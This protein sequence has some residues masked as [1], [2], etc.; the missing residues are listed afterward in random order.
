MKDY[1]KNTITD[2]IFWIFVAIVFIFFG[3]LS[4][5][6]FA[7]DT[8]A[9]LSFTMKDFINQFASS[10][11]FL[12]VFVG[13]ILKILNLNGKVIYTLSYLMAIICMIISLYKLYTIIKDDVKSSI[14]KVLIPT[15]IVLNAFSLE[16][17]LF[18]EKG[19]MLFGVMMS[20][21]AVGEIKKWLE[22]KNKK[23]LIFTLVYMLFA[24]FSYQGIVGIFVAISVIYIVKYSKNIKEFIINNIVVAIQYAIP[25]IIDYVLIKILYAS[26]RV[27]GQ[28]ILSE[29]IRKIC[30]STKS[31]ILGTYNMLPKYLFAIL[32][33]AIFCVIVY[34]IIIQKSSI[35]NK[36]IEILK[37]IY[38]I[39]AVIFASIAPQIMQNTDSIWFVA[40]ST[41]SYA[42]LFGVLM[43]YLFT[44]F[45]NIKKLNMNFLITISLILLVVQFNRFNVI[46]ISRYKTNEMDYEITRKI[47]TKITEYEEQTGNTIKNIALYEDKSMSYAYN[48]IFST[49]DT[50]IK[51]YAKDWC[52]TYILKYYFNINLNN[53]EQNL[54]IKEN[55]ENKDWNEFNDDQLIF[56]GDTLHLCK[57]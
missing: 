20:I 49:G 10:G 18:V 45:E 54:E 41:Y 9:T 40:R 2:K 31:M 32:V 7:V 11:R 42:S 1:I 26:S 38:I 28:I 27:N 50:N 39:I 57:Y 12:L 16:L 4:Q 5:M 56:D 37:V 47:A 3:V 25:A 55:F 13:I 22:N 53:V 44:N 43:L 19:I 21:F 35:K 48:G 6:E 15:L 36:T 30:T 46:E 51:A 24:N 14:L 17:F 34:Q 8:Y 33:F 52:I 29:S 23:S